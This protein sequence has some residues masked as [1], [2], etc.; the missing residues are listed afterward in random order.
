MVRR[1]FLLSCSIY[2]GS[3]CEASWVIWG[4]LGR[5]PS[6]LMV[7]SLFFFSS[8]FSTSD[9]SSQKRVEKNW[10]PG[11]LFPA[12]NLAVLFPRVTTS[13]VTLRRSAPISP[14]LFH[15]EEPTFI[16]T[17]AFLGCGGVILPLVGPSFRFS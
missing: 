17:I 5:R 14:P 11:A 10:K 6:L 15:F 3:A 13:R 4:C 8:L 7:F 16:L 1:G 9:P 12:F 2:P